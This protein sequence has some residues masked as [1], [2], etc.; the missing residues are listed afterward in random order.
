MRFVTLSRFVC[1]GGQITH[2]SLCEVGRA[3]SFGVLVTDAN[4]PRADSKLAQA[5]RQPSLGDWL[6]PTEREGRDS[7]PRDN[8]AAGGCTRRCYLQ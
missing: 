2:K 8:A 5:T 6:A 4:I 7:K 1:P 3:V